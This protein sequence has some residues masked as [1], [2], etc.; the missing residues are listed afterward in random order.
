M[1]KERQRNSKSQIQGERAGIINPKLLNDCSLLWAVS[2]MQLKN[3]ARCPVGCWCEHGDF[4]TA[5]PVQCKG[6]HGPRNVYDEALAL[7][8]GDQTGCFQRHEV[9][10][11]TSVW[12]QGLTSGEGRDCQEQQGWLLGEPCPVTFLVLQVPAPDPVSVVPGNTSG[13]SPSAADKQGTL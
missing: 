3:E 5:M 4:I 10:A 1:E 13:F 8:G 9:K 11:A 6:K 12:L 7:K 2:A